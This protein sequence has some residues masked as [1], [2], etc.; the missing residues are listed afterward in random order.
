MEVITTKPIII[1]F[2]GY[3]KQFLSAHCCQ[4]VSGLTDKEILLMSHTST[5]EF[6]S[7][8]DVIKV[9]R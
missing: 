1:I 9:A 5:L 4:T 3:D 6:D 2:G 7:L 8:Y